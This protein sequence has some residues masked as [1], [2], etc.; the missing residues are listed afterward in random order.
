MK[1]TQR[2]SISIVEGTRL[3]EEMLPRIKNKNAWKQKRGGLRIS[4]KFTNT[5]M[6]PFRPI[7][8]IVLFLG[9]FVFT[10]CED[11]R[12][13]PESKLPASALAFIERFYVDQ[14]IIQIVQDFDESS[15]SR[16][17]YVTLQNLTRLE[18][19]RK[20][21]ITEIE[22]RTAIPRGAIDA[23]LLDKAAEF[24]PKIE[25]FGWELDRDGQELRLANGVTLEFTRDGQFLRIDD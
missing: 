23:R 20:G 13:I 16:E 6:Q 9:L 7:Y 14:P 12:V 2:T 5:T 19:N 18:F 17:Y 4:W 21:E 10:S 25:A 3:A 24:F 8:V 15:L 1:K 11:D 22:G